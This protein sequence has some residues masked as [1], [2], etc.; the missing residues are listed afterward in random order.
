MNLRTA[1][2]PRSGAFEATAGFA[3]AKAAG[4]SNVRGSALL[5]IS[6]D[7]FLSTAHKQE[8]CS[9]IKQSGLASGVLFR[10]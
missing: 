9:V 6:L 4:G 5:G 1:Q 2:R 10:P 3:S 7:E 8:L